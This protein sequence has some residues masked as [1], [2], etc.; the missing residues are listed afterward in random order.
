MI[1]SKRGKRQ[2]KKNLKIGNKSSSKFI[3]K[4]NKQNN[5]RK[6]LKQRLTNKELLKIREQYTD[7][8]IKNAI[9]SIET[10][11]GVYSRKSALSLILL[12][13][14][15]GLT[16]KKS[17]RSQT[18]KKS[19]NK[20]KKK[21]YEINNKQEYRGNTIIWYIIITKE[22]IVFFNRRVYIVL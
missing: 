7:K 19:K 8:Q 11:E 1:S 22:Y 12:G 9:E 15:L 10:M 2:S 18:K 5:L 21:N 16:K 14:M 13:T 3:R 4:M 20:P 6:R 17:K